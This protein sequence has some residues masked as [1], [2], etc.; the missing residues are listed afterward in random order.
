MMLAIFEATRQHVEEQKVNEYE[1]HQFSAFASDLGIRPGDVFT[2]I[3]TD[4][5]NGRSFILERVEAELTVYKQAH[6]CITL[7]IFND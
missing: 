2:S 3:W 1:V 6:G 4:L 5:G 7:T